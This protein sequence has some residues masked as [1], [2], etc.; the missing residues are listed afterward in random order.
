MQYLA[1]WFIYYSIHCVSRQIDLGMQSIWLSKHCGGLGYNTVNRIKYFKFAWKDQVYKGHCIWNKFK[2]WE[3]W[4]KSA[5]LQTCRDDI[6]CT[7]KDVRKLQERIAYEC[8]Y[9]IGAHKV[10]L[11]GKRTTKRNALVNELSML[12]WRN[13][14]KNGGE[15]R[16]SKQD[17]M[18]LV[19][20]GHIQSLVLIVR[21]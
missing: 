16:I 15:R 11:Y 3:S 12:K 5:W 13:G 14:C 20:W 17:F 4:Y 7:V 9:F 19:I 8:G 21:R 1:V 18:R 6:Y 2:F 10:K